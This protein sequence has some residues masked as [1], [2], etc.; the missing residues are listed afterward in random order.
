MS[1]R[2]DIGATARR[3]IRHA[4]ITALLWV[5]QSGCAAQAAD[6]QWRGVNISGAELNYS[7]GHPGRLS[8]DY[9]YP[10]DRELD[11][12]ADKG[13]NIIR[14]PVRW[15]RLQQEIGGELDPK[16]LASLKHVIDYAARRKLSVIVDIHNFGS[17]RDQKLGSE[18]VPDDALA[19]LWAPLAH[20]F[21]TNPRV[22][23]G[24]MNEPIG[25]SPELLAKASQA[26]I[27]EIRQTGAQNTILVPGAGWSSAYNFVSGS[28][29]ALGTIHDPAQHWA[30]EV[31]QYFDSNRSGVHA[32]CAAAADA[33][34]MLTEVTQWASA[35]QAK[36]FLGEFA[37]GRS[38]D[39]LA[40]LSAL[41]T[42]LSQNQATWQGWTFWAGGPWWGDYHFT[43]EPLNGTDRPQMGVLQRLLRNTPVGPETG[44]TH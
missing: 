30:Y 11:Y 16:E 39:C 22:I 3:M 40:A 24:L 18:G 32:D 31:H 36:L 27:D 29:A 33:V 2:D 20:E 7:R 4:V 5:L 9:I 23:F 25:V 19:K 12:F 42:Y 6:V 43:L 17:Y 15:E 10:S 26:A 35:H 44:A 28:A 1:R 8:F 37:V 38:D 21:R 13:A 34:G 14:V 41:L